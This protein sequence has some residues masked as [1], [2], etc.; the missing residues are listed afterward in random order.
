MSAWKTKRTSGLSTPMPK[1][2]VA[3]TTQAVLAQKRVLVGDPHGM[4]EAGVIG[5][6]RGR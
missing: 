1:A 4:V 3:Q 6:A 5:R 2:T